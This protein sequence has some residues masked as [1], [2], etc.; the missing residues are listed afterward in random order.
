MSKFAY[1]LFERAPDRE[2][3]VV[4]KYPGDSSFP[5]TGPFRDGVAMNYIKRL[6]GLSRETIAIHKG[7]LYA[8]APD[9]GPQYDDLKDVTDPA[10]RGVGQAAL[11]EKVHARQRFGRCR[12]V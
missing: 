5:R 12:C 11:A 3:V 8:L 1:D 10:E 7:D 9:K 2:D 4:F 6:V